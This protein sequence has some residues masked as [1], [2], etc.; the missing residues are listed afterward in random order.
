MLGQVNILPATN[1]ENIAI[2]EEPPFPDPVP[3]PEDIPPFPFS[4]SGSENDPWDET[5]F[6]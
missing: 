3:E 5:E 1:R 6:D 2:P 4:D